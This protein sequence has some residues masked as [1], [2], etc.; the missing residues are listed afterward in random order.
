MAALFRDQPDESG[1]GLFSALDAG[2]ELRDAAAGLVARRDGLPAG[3]DVLDVRFRPRRVDQP[4]AA[5]PDLQPGLLGLCR[6]SGAGE[7]PRCWRRSRSHPQPDLL[8]GPFSARGAG[9]QL[10]PWL[11]L[12]AFNLIADRRAVS[13]LGFLAV[14]TMIFLSGHI[15]LAALGYEVLAVG[16][17]AWGWAHRREPRKV[18]TGYAL[19]GLAALLGYLAVQIQ[20]LPTQELTA[21]ASAG[22]G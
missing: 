10:A 12:T 14:N 22:S 13:L 19:F 9:Q 2:V 7:W 21:T 1:R 4:L 15:E 8:V 18:A 6:R 3:R 17:L 16:L 11:L 20:T 5:R